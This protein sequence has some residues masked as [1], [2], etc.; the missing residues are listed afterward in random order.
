MNINITIITSIS[1]LTISITS[2]IVNFRN[3]IIVLLTFELILLSIIMLFAST[4]IQTSSNLNT[5]FIALI[6]SIAASETATGLTILITHYRI[7]GSISIKIL[8]L[9]RG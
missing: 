5:V 4:S 3:I 2:L 6:L 9:L 8:N 1:I 7:R